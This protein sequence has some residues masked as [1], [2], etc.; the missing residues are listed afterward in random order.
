MSILTNSTSQQ[1]PDQSNISSGNLEV[2][3]L[4]KGAKCNPASSFFKVPPCSG[5]YPNYEFYIYSTNNA[6][7]K[8]TLIS[9]AKTDIDGN[10]RVSLK[11]NKYVIQTE[12][13][14][15]SSTPYSFSIKEGERVTI[16]ITIDTGI[17]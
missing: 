7:L 6:D 9:K 4:F 16:V 14:K 8:K 1:I 2:K 12:S 15:L 13:D 5:P 11:P 3:I 17:R 10:Y